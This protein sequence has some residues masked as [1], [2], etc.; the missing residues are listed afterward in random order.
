MP[1]KIQS[2]AQQVLQSIGVLGGQFLDAQQERADKEREIIGG[3]IDFIKNSSPIASA[4]AMVGANSVRPAFDNLNKA[5]AGTQTEAAMMVNPDIKS[6]AERDPLLDAGLK[7][8]KKMQEQQIEEAAMS[9]VPS[10][11]LLRT[12]INQS[13]Q[14]ANAGLIQPAGIPDPTK[15]SKND[16]PPGIAPE[17]VSLVSAGKEQGSSETDPETRNA[18]QKLLGGI[19]QGAKGAGTGFFEGFGSQLEETKARTDL[20]KSQSEQIKQRLAGEEPLQEGERQKLEIAHKNAIEQIMIEEGLTGEQA[21]LSKVTGGL[22]DVIS[23]R[24]NVNLRGNILGPLGAGLGF[25]GID[26]KDRGTYESA[27]NQFVFDVGELLGQSGR[28]FTEKE[29][30]LV[31][32]EVLALSTVSKESKFKGKLQAVIN[33]INSK[34]GEKIIPDIDVL[35]NSVEN[36]SSTDRPSSRNFKTSSGRNFIIEQVD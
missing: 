10:S 9:G 34:Y 22:L 3:L 27:A 6:L 14:R 16:Q 15:K 33:R 12:L 20:I 7:K 36:D 1:N 31:R 29:Q 32:E 4:G 25:L 19:V 26:S 35:Y 28:A 13:Q 23:A 24:K 5:L 18:F 2:Q 21:T 8:V 17:G 30:K 11:D